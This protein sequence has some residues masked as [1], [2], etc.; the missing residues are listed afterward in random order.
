MTDLI[1]LAQTQ[2]VPVSVVNYP[3]GHHAFEMVDDEAATRDVID[4]TLDFVARSTAPAYQASLR[5]ACPKPPPPRVAAG[6]FA[7]AATVYAIWSRRAR[8]SAAA[9]VVRRG[10]AR[11]AQF[12]AACSVFDQLKGKG[13][14]PRDLGLPAA[15]ACLQKGD[16]EAAMA[17]CVDPVALP[18]ADDRER[19]GLRPAPR[20]RR[21][22]GAVR[23]GRRP[24][25]RLGAADATAGRRRSRST[26]SL[27]R[28]D[29]CSP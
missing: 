1:T 15:R 13:L 26:L 21:L 9:P 27:A 28:R 18:A 23:G 25:R 29:R 2:N 4:A 12:A 5:A 19:A 16:A 20:T 11:R 24:R 8:G 17:G 7:A 14:G 22:Q 10:A 6:E 3:G